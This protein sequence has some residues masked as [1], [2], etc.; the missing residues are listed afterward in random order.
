MET[1]QFNDFL[2][3]ANSDPIR[4]YADLSEILLGIPTN[5]Q[6]QFQIERD[7]TKVKEVQDKIVKLFP[8]KFK[9]KDTGQI[10]G[11]SLA[12]TVIPL[13]GDFL[14]RLSIEMKYIQQGGGSNH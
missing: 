1:E 14:Q 5:L 4:F 10:D 2:L 13:L 11:L 9:G 6:S 7:L 8:Q 12:L 3:L